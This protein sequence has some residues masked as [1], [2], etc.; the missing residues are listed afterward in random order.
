MI[1]KCVERGI[2]VIT[3]TQMLESMIEN[4]SAT[5]AEI[6]DVANAA[7]DFTD[8]TM[9]SGETAFGKYPDQVVATM[10]KTVTFTEK[11]IKYDMTNHFDYHIADRQ[12]MV[13]EAAYNLFQRLTE[14]SD[15]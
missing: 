1:K 2:P 7:Y 8:A 10:A 4:P 12:E 9:L 6:S 14:K 3:A 5:R 11:K 15:A 13:C